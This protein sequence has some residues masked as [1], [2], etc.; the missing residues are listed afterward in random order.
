MTDTNQI[1]HSA[2]ALRDA[3]GELVA[4]ERRLS[5]NNGGADY[6]SALAGKV[7]EESKVVYLQARLMA[8]VDKYRKEFET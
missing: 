2:C 1:V 3:L 6:F 7:G 5:K 8:E 4:A